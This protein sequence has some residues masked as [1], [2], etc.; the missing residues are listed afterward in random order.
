[1]AASPKLAPQIEVA[2]EKKT[3]PAAKPEPAGLKQRL[4]ALMIE[5]FKGRQEYLGWTPE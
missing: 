2:W 5:I 3:Q 1:M 4:R